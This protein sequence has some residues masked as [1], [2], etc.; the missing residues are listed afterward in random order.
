MKTS[1]PFEL[2]YTD[3]AGPLTP[4][5]KDGAKYFSKFTDHHTRWKAVYPISSKSEA[6]ETLTYF[7]Q[8]YVIPI[9]SRIQRLRCDKGGE[10][11]A[12]YYKNFCK[13][14]GIQQEFA[15]TNTPQ[16]IGMSERDGRT[17]MN[18][19][20]C[21]LIDTGLPKFLWGELCETA[22]YLINRFPHRSLNGR[23]PYST[24]FGKEPNLS[25]LRGDWC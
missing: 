18:M 14:T 1:A 17:I 13:V 6:L 20:R 9:K 15:A 16:Q 8:D 25:R 11:T 4:Q 21:I 3:L 24:L 7:T 23:S 12:D 19:V 5:A 22:A 10:Y 2:V